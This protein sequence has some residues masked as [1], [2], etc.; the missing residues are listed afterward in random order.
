MSFDKEKWDRALSLLDDND[1]QS[2]LF[3]F[4][5][6]YEDGHQAAARMIAAIYEGNSSDD[7]LQDCSKAYQ[8][9]EKSAYEAGDI[10]GYV[11]LARAHFYGVGVPKDNAKALSFLEELKNHDH[12]II[13]LLKGKIFLE[14]ER[15]TVASKFLNDSRNKGNIVAI[16]YLSALYRK[17]GKIMKSKKYK[18]IGVLKWFFAWYKNEHSEYVNDL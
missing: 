4:R 16:I 1:R 15:Y 5:R 11:G 7:N 12:H 18:I 9:Y 2:A 17:Q 14:E 8:W 6:L 10:M 13:D 3:L